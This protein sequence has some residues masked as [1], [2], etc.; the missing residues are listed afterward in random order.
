MPTSHTRKKIID[1][2]RQLFARHSVDSTTVIDIATAA[3]VSRRTMYAYFRSKEEVFLAVVGTE[4]DIL[5]D[6]MKRVAARHLPPR[7]KVMQ[8]VYTHLN[9][10]RGVVSR[11]GNLRAYFFRDSW[12]VEK[13]R[14]HFDADTIGLYR[15]ALAE[16]VDTGVFHIDDLDLTAT[17]L[18]HSVK[19]LE[20]PYIR[21]HIGGH[22]DQETRKRYVERLVLGAL[23]NERDI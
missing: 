13:A 7:E 18:H 9:A 2:A 14:R 17:I 8:L 5:S 1:T 4:L 3:G 15:S 6:I 22:L 19:G 20:A 11:N 23:T 12:A 21:G 10:V 16:G